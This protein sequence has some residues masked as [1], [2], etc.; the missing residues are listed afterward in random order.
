MLVVLPFIS[1]VLKLPY[2]AFSCFFMS[3]YVKLDIVALASCCLS[4]VYL[5]S[6][7]YLY[8]SSPLGNSI[9]YFL[10]YYKAFQI[11][12]ESLQYSYLLASLNFSNSSYAI[13]AAWVIYFA[14]SDFNLNKRILTP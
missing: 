10:Y 5:H 8:A 12:S 13:N 4:S 7:C 11:R 9:S 14:N 1:L 3:S 6:I 2:I